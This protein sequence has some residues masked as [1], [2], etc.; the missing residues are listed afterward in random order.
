MFILLT[1]AQPAWAQQAAEII[2]DSLIGL[3]VLGFILSVLPIWTRPWLLELAAWVV[4]GAGV[5]LVLL[6]IGLVIQANVVGGAVLMLLFL[7]YLVY[8]LRCRIA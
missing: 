1:S 5:P 3:L 6:L 2:V 4:V 7:A 8:W